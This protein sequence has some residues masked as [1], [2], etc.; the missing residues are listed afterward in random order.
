MPEINSPFPIAG[1]PDRRLG[2]IALMFD[3]LTIR[4]LPHCEF[5]GA[6][7]IAESGHPVVENMLFQRLFFD[8]PENTAVV[9]PVPRKKP[10]GSRFELP[11]SGKPRLMLL[12]KITF[13]PPA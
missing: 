11:G 9:T 7:L 2:F 10:E 6:G 8:P 5:V 1:L 3:W 4:G 13:A 12:L